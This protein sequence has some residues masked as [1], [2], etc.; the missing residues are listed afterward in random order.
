MPDFKFRTKSERD[1][2]PISAFGDPGARLFPVENQADLDSAAH[3]IGK[4]KNPAAVK[5]RLIAIAK[6]LKLK[7]PD[8]W[9]A[10]ASMSGGTAEHIVSIATF[11][12]AGATVE[13]DYVIRSGKLFE[14]GDFEDKGFQM[15]PEEMVA[16]IDQFQVCPVD[17]EHTDSV[18]TG[19]LGEVRSI[20]L[21][22]DGWSLNGTVALPQWLDDA[23]GDT[24]CKVSATWDRESKTLQGLALV[25]NPRVEDAALMAAFA[26]AR[27]DTPH[28]RMALQDLHDAS[29]RNGAIC[30]ASNATMA[31]GHEASAI[32]S[33]HD[34]AVAHGAA[35]AALKAG[36]KP[37]YPMFGSDQ[38][39][40]STP[41]TTARKERPRM[42]FKDTLKS[43]FDLG[44]PDEFEPVEPTGAAP[45]TPPVVATPTGAAVAAAM[46]AK[47]DPAVEAL[48]Q[49]NDRA[50]QFEA[51]NRRL[52]TERI[53]DEAV[54]FADDQI[55]EGRAFPAE[56]EQIIAV[57][58]TA[59]TDDANYGAVTFGDGTTGARVDGVRK[60]Y[61]SRPSNQLTKEQIQSTVFEM[62]NRT[63]TSQ[64]SE[65]A[66]SEERKNELIGMTSLGAS[67]LAQKNGSN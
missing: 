32:Q 18:L 67:H 57:F 4:A 35:C 47:P 54:R 58:T 15:S 6:R 17:L 33:I 44:M 7:V 42:S 14:C 39:G 10:A 60:A 51:E 38:S 48:R 2:L 22:E 56:R 28:G 41:P 27:H 53:R 63:K 61:E 34:T 50:A 26:A 66:P 40:E 8:A 59:A 46:A 55:R 13:G 62:A 29:A 65:G 64:P 24:P 31:S 3:L 49:A 45:A 23:I 25:L 1:A 52:K 16:A 43:W 36:T 37:G 12:L 11:D 30:K 9:Q 20:E 19:K 5:T 21:A